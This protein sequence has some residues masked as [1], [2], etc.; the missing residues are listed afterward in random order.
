MCLASQ[1]LPSLFNAATGKAAITRTDSGRVESKSINQCL[2]FCFDDYF[3]DQRFGQR[4]FDEV[5]LHIDLI[6]T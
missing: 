5:E 1:R 2:Y 6:F 4:I 3:E